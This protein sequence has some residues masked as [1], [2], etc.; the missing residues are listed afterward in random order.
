[1]IYPQ[2]TYRHVEI[3]TQTKPNKTKLIL[4]WDPLTITGCK[5]ELD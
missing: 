3:K 1:M 2:H 5:M 4:V